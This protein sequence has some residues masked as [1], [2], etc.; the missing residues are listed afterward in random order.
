MKNS[1]V[2][3]FVTLKGWSGRKLLDPTTYMSTAKL[4]IYTHSKVF[5]ASTDIHHGEFGTRINYVMQIRMDL[6]GRTGL[7]R[8]KITT[9]H[10]HSE[11]TNKPNTT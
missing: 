4:L 10:D 3:L 8:N 1:K 2:V 7:F 6:G 9:W 5:R 11:V